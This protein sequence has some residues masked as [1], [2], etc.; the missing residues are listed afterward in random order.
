MIDEIGDLYDYGKLRQLGEATMFVPQ[1]SSLLLVLGGNQSID[2]LDSS[3]LE[4]T[5]VRRRRGGGGLVLLRPGDLWI[6]WWIPRNDERWS[7]DV[8]E[9]SRRAG[10]WWA[11]SLRHVLALDVTVYSGPVE[12]DD[13]Y[14]VVCFSGRG[15]GEV[16]VNGRKTV[17]ISQWRVREGVLL[18]TVLHARSTSDVVDWLADEPAGLRE[19]LDHVT[20]SSFDQPDVQGL[21]DNVRHSSGPWRYVEPLI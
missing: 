16:F 7:Y 19:A 10:L 12:V 2:V 3:R 4:A 11:D 14:R 9:S 21:L 8:H 18:S 1:T 17:G 5:N 15:P 20:F 13:R 6:D